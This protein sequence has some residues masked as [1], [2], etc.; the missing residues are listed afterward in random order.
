MEETYLKLRQSRKQKELGAFVSLNA[1]SGCN[2]IGYSSEYCQRN[3]QEGVD[4]SQK[5]L[6]IRLGMT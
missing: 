6:L 4:D 5:N 2:R 1:C 3:Y